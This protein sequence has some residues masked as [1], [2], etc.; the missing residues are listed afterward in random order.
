MQGI[1]VD[2]GVQEL[3]L[4]PGER[5]GMHAPSAAAAPTLAPV[6]AQGAAAAAEQ[7]ATQ[8]QQQQPTSPKRS[9]AVV[10][11]VRGRDRRRRLAV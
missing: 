9:V 2:G 11:G 3:P 8:Q 7:Q 6:P 1:Y 4:Q 5:M 10:S